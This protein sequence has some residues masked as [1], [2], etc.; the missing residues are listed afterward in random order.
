MSLASVSYRE[1]EA[2]VEQWSNKYQ[3]HIS[4]HDSKP[5]QVKCFSP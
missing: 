1:V 2:I 4:L 5:Q 3:Y